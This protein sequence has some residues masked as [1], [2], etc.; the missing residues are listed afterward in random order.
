MFWIIPL[1]TK[2][3]HEMKRLLILEWVP[4]LLNGGCSNGLKS[5]VLSLN[6]LT[7]SCQLLLIYHSQCINLRLILHSHHHLRM[8]IWP[9]SHD[10]ATPTCNVIFVLP[11]HVIS[12][13]LVCYPGHLMRRRWQLVVV[14]TVFKRARAVVLTTCI[15]LLLTKCFTL[16]CLYVLQVSLISQC[17]LCQR[18]S[19]PRCTTSSMYTSSVR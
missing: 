14:H 16:A 3:L 12:S 8:L 19:R 10:A 13:S 18:I 4:L 9:L 15:L 11:T 1:R 7:K 17:R 6:G 5:F 2:G